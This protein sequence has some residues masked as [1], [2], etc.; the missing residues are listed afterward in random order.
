VGGLPSQIGI[1]VTVEEDTDDWL[2]EN[3]TQRSSSEVRAEGKESKEG[4][5]NEGT[6]GHF[7]QIYASTCSIVAIEEMFA[8][9]K[10]L[11]SILAESVLQVLPTVPAHSITL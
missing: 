2:V 7:L 5:C 3:R 11:Y 6:E 8:A 9:C 1:D 10:F 4:V